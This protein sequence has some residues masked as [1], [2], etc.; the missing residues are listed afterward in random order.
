[1]S[2][3]IG[4]IACGYSTILGGTCNNV[5]SISIL[6]G[7]CNNVSSIY[8]TIIGGYN[9]NVGGYC[10]NINY[11]TNKNYLAETFMKKLGITED[12]LRCDP[13]WIKSKIRDHAIDSILG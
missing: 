1:M 6:G 11:Y 5:S 7:T 13:S 3:H 2:Y 10:S 4:Q 9:N 8:G 12:D